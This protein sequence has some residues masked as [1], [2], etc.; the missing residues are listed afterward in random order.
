MRREEG[1]PGAYTDIPEFDEGYKSPRLRGPPGWLKK[2]R[3]RRGCKGPKLMLC[4]KSARMKDL[5]WT[6]KPPKP[7]IREDEEEDGEEE[8]PET[9]V[10]QQHVGNTPRTTRSGRQIK[11]VV[12]NE[13]DLSADAEEPAE[14]IVAVTSSFTSINNVANGSA[15]KP[16]S[17]SRTPLPGLHSARAT[18]S[19]QST[20]H[21][22]SPVKSTPVR[23]L[24]RSLAALEAAGDKDEKQTEPARTAATS[25]APS[26]DDDD[27]LLESQLVAEASA[28]Q[29][30]EDSELSEVDEMDLDKDAH[31]EVEIDA[32][33]DERSQM[34]DDELDAAAN[35]MIPDAAVQL[36]VVKDGVVGNLCLDME[37]TNATFY[38]MDNENLEDKLEIAISSITNVP[39]IEEGTNSFIIVHHLDDEED[40]MEYAFRFSSRSIEH[41]RKV[42]DELASA[43]PK[44]K[45]PLPAWAYPIPN[46]GPKPFRCDMCDG[47]WKNYEGIKYHK[48]KAKSQCNP[49]WVPPAPGEEGR[50]GKRKGYVALDE[51]PEEEREAF[52]KQKEEEERRAREEGVLDDDTPRRRQSRKRATKEKALESLEALGNELAAE[53]AARA[54]RKRKKR[55][56]KEQLRMQAHMQAAQ[57]GQAAHLQHEASAPSTPKPFESLP[58]SRQG[59][60][61]AATPEKRA[62][63]SVK[64]KLKYPV[65]N[66]RDNVDRRTGPLVT[67]R[68]KDIILELLSKYNNVFP[69]DQGLW[70][71]FHKLWMEKYP[72]TVVQDYKYCNA[73]VALL[74]DQ[75]CITKL[76]FSFRDNKGR[77]RTRSVITIKG[78]DPTGP[79]V[80]AIKEHIKA[81]FPRYWCPPEFSPPDAE[82]EM[83]AARESR[84]SEE[85]RRARQEARERE[86]AANPQLKKAKEA[87]ALIEARIISHAGVT[88]AQNDQDDDGESSEEELAIL[89]APF[90]APDTNGD[91]YHDSDYRSPA[92]PVREVPKQKRS[93]SFRAGQSA[94]MKDV[95]AQLKNQSG[96]LLRNLKTHEMLRMD[97]RTLVVHVG[98]ELYEAERSQEFAD[99]NYPPKPEIAPAVMQDAASGAWNFTPTPGY[100][101]P[102][103]RLP[104]PITY[105]QNAVTSAW[106]VRPFGHGALPIFARPS[107]RFG[108]H[109]D[110]SSSESSFR[111]VLIPQG[112]LESQSRQR[113]VKRARERDNEVE[114]AAVMRKRARDMQK[115][116]DS[117][118]LATFADEVRPFEFKP[119]EKPR[120]ARR[121]RVLMWEW[122]LNPGLDSLVHHLPE[123]AT[124][125]DSGRKHAYVPIDPALLLMGSGT[126]A[127]NLEAVD[128][129]ASLFSMGQARFLEKLPRCLDDILNQVPPPDLPDDDTPIPDYVAA[130]VEFDAVAAW[131][132]SP[133]GS[134]I[135]NMGKIADGSVFINHNPY[136][137]EDA[138]KTNVKTIIWP[139]DSQFTLESLPYDLIDSMDLD[140]NSSGT[141]RKPAKRT[142]YGEPSEYYGM[143]EAGPQDMTP[144]AVGQRTR[145]AIEQQLTSRTSRVYRR[146]AQTKDFKK[147]RL[148]SLP[149]DVNGLVLPEDDE[150]F[151]V[152]IAYNVL[153]RNQ[154]RRTNDRMVVSSAFDDRLMVSVVVIRTLLGGLDLSVDWVLVSLL[155]PQCT[156][157]WLRRHWNLLAEKH[158]KRIERLQEAFQEAYLEAYAADEVP[159]LDYDDLLAYDWAG[160]V[161]WT[162]HRTQ[163]ASDK[164]VVLP[165]SRE[166]FDELYSLADAETRVWRDSYFSTS[167]PVHKRIAHAAFGNFT[168]PASPDVKKEQPCS[169]DE[170]MLR[171]ARSWA[172]ANTLTPAERYDMPSAST[173]LRHLP[174]EI[175]GTAIEQLLDS[176]VIMP[177]NKGRPAPGRGYEGTDALFAS[178]T[179]HLKPEH[180]AEAI[181]FKTTLD[182]AFRK[183]ES[184]PLD[185]AAGEGTIM[186]IT[187]LQAAKRVVV[188]RENVPANKFGL[189]DGNYQTKQMDKSRLLFDMFAEPSEEY[190]FDDYPELKPVVRALNKRSYEYKEPPKLEGELAPIPLWYGIDGELIEPIWKKVV[191]AVLVTIMGRPGISASDVARLMRPAVEE[192]EV[193]LWLEWAR[194]VGAVRELSVGEAKG[195]TVGEWWWW[196]A[197]HV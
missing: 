148:T 18:R 70:F 176:K 123:Y 139:T 131:E 79:E 72:D 96:T 107:K 175:I 157:N 49:D 147:R 93:E 117:D 192:W 13:V 168:V 33:H 67:Q 17:A 35:V 62:L 61:A 66:D 65:V 111:P 146:F 87:E 88:A 97:D 95:W 183:G 46:G 154:R 53:E 149:M 38:P 55:E 90:Y 5:D 160:L 196:V 45:P 82:V 129:N 9:P 162:M 173:K 169:G 98:D 166:R 125:V 179:R 85:E 14:S 113:G 120:Y 99:Q 41:A 152:D 190:V 156:L 24:R 57:A 74:E 185:Y 174:R 182:V 165:R 167:L 194:G 1:I 48:T 56:M 143:T 30:A 12:Y 112:R 11:K 22:Q 128:K 172:R 23:S 103:P 163:L 10:P 188:R 158:S 135:L 164:S 43:C 171:V 170:E 136:I 58:V 193:E 40:K 101:L 115:Q 19:G 52:L 130:C 140:D 81:S 59:T 4:F 178:L 3:P 134:G 26:G 151:R 187:N 28:A 7:H 20:P 180:F 144:E 161:D 127:Q 184:V 44:Y 126:A 71:A 60:P 177:A 153:N 80:T 118:T 132:Q 6:E 73:A 108:A 100:T 150:E 27:E 51:L 122:S 102:Q 54:E 133:T 159:R 92:R 86:E 77:L 155:F 142:R 110:L 15:E 195:W 104:E 64:T 2:G 191:G 119:V 39:E 75:G 137:P 36:P 68:R 197:G 189:T 106:S 89:T 124:V 42:V 109:K 16:R 8:V 76:K 34:I 37:K 25:V 116:R 83:L 63:L 78:V 94:R 31:D 69:G 114:A 32:Q 47:Q 121:Q 91:A 145:R 29:D 141:R 50:K 84:P 181:N 138:I 186:A 105:M 21:P